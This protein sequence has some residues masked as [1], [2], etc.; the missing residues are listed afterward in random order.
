VTRAT[1]FD[2]QELD[3]HGF[4]D[5][6]VQV[7]QPR[8]GYR[9]GADT[10]LLAAACP[11]RAGQGVLDLGCG[12]GV[13]S[14][15][16]AMRVGDLR[17]HGLEAQP[18]YADLARRNAAALGT[19]MTVHEGDVAAIPTSLR[20]VQVDHVIANPPY[21]DEA[22]SS[23]TLDDGKDRAFRADAPVSVWVD[24]GLRRLVPGGWLTMV[25]RTACLPAI[26]AA[27]EGRAGAVAILPLAARAGRPA[28]RII[29]RARKGAA[30][31]LTLHAPFVMHDG[32]RHGNDADPFSEGA[33][34]V[35]RGSEAL[36]F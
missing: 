1:P 14:F 21:F 31:P 2:A 16:L 15:C 11:A 4:L 28:D 22:A 33:E 18:A 23:G 36:D 30:T 13:A 20:A 19:A 7:W 10:V 32:A 27:L 8:K 5:G 6:R 25:H 24:A 9:S 34:R 26:L 35:L 17:L 29:L 12:A 3:R